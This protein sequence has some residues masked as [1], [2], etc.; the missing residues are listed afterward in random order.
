MTHCLIRFVEDGKQK[1]TVVPSNWVVDGVLYW[2]DSLNARRDFKIKVA[3]PP[4]PNWLKYEIEK[5]VVIEGK[6]KHQFC[7]RNNEMMAQ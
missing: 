1:D 2:S 3:P 4:Q 7:C 6:Y 5:T